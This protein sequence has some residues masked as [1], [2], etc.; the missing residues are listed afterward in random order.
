MH[1]QP[2]GSWLS[3]LLNLSNCEAIAICHRVGDAN[4]TAKAAGAETEQGNG[5]M[6]ASMLLPPMV[7]VCSSN[8][9]ETHLGVV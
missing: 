8:W 1:A 5:L 4:S 2:L 6:V 7:L 3:T 9:S